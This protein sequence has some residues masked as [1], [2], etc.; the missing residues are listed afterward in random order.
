M[1]EFV[2]RNNYFEFNL[3]AKHQ[4]W[5][6]AIGTNFVPSYA[7]IF[8]DCIERV[9]LK[10]NQIQPWIWIRYTDD[11]FFIWAASQKELD[12]FLNRAFKVFTLI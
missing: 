10:S 8:M 5:R 12:K 1:A 7:Y 9:F 6:T 4:I 3:T 11:I 2:L